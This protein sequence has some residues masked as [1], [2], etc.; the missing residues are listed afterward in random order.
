MHTTW[1]SGALRDQDQSSSRSLAVTGLEDVNLWLELMTHKPTT[2]ATASLS[3]SLVPCQSFTTSFT[4]RQLLS[5]NCCI[6]MH[7]C[8]SHMCTH[9]VSAHGLHRVLRPIM[10]P[11]WH[12]TH[13][14]QQAY[15]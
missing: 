11:R 10:P 5:T 15:G 13:Q 2:W 8:R 9:W 14:Q 4:A 6:S 12:Y 7:V 1:K 3:V